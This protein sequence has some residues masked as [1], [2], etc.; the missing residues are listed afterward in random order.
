MNRRLY[1]PEWIP[2]GYRVSINES[3][4]S[5]PMMGQIRFKFSKYE[6]NSLHIQENLN[7]IYQIAKLGLSTILESNKINCVGVKTTDT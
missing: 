3:I 6:N 2:I 1:Y 5:I 7:Q 4:L